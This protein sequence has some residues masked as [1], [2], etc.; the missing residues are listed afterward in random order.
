MDYIIRILRQFAFYIF[1][2]FKIR[3]L[4]KTTNKNKLDLLKWGEKNVR[5]NIC[6]LRGGKYLIDK[7]QKS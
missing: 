3:F 1:K 2:T 5:E 6:G 4:I 7:K